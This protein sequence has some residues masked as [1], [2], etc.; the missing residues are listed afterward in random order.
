VRGALEGCEIVDIGLPTEHDAVEIVMQA[1]GL[2]VG[3]RVPPGARDVARLCKLLPLTLGI[4]GRLVRDLALEDDWS[5]AVT[6]IQNELASEARSVEDSVICSSLQALKGSHQLPVRTLLLAFALCPEDVKVPL[7]VLSWVVEAEL[8]DGSAAPSLLHMRRWTKMLIDRSLVLGPLENPSLHD[9]V[10]DFSISQ[11]SEDELRAAQ[12]R[13]V[14][15]IRQRRPKHEHSELSGWDNSVVDDRLSQYIVS[16]SVYHV[17]MAWE[18][19]W[20]L[21]E[22]AISW[23]DDFTMQQDCIPLAAAS[24]LG[25]SKC[26]QLAERA[27]QEGHW[28]KAAKRWSASAL[29][30]LKVRGNAAAVPLWKK[31]AA[32]MLQAQ[33]SDDGQAQ[34]I[35]LLEFVT[36][37][38]ILTSWNMA[39]GP[40]YRPRVRELLRTD[41]TKHDPLLAFTGRFVVEVYVAFESGIVENF[42]R[43]GIYQYTETVRAANEYERGH[44]VRSLLL[45]CVYG[46]ATLRV[47]DKC[48]Q[49][50]PLVC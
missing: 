19:V 32:A 11:H 7:E 12:R 6:L 17:K 29:S 45:C 9:I 2:E 16:Y 25:P 27:E 30:E 49:V 34:Q 37:L 5:E 1:A 48:A 22:S 41:V 14:N 33:P 21:D 24:A 26:A 3:A 47:M 39:D 38:K 36:L 35:N 42:G 40:V 15:L 18:Q 28:W 43:A 46:F 8:G 31:A 23:L 20:A 10:L 13:L 44:P 50:R 4:A